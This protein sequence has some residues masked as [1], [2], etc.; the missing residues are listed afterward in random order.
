MLTPA[1]KNKLSTLPTP[2]DDMYM[3]QM[4]HKSGVY[5]QL[6]VDVLS[7][8]AVRSMRITGSNGTLLWN[9]DEKR[10]LLFS[11]KSQKWETVEV[12]KGTAHKGYINPEEPYINEI[13]DFLKVCEKNSKPEYTLEDDLETLRILE[14]AELS[15]QSGKRITI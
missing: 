8:P 12:Q 5:G 15:S 1:I 10:I 11:A 13:K 6:I 7:K 14:K 9:D 4:Q 2:I 3:L